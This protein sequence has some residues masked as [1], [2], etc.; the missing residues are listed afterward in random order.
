MGRKAE[1]LSFFDHLD[2]LR[3][4]LIK[5]AA[6]V[7]LF[8]FGAYH[9]KDAILLFFTRTAGELV[10]TAPSDAFAVSIGV[11][12]FVGMLLAMP[13][14]LFQLWQFLSSALKEDERKAIYV[15]GPASLLLFI[16]G[17]LFAYFIVVP[18]SF[19]FLMSFSSDILVPMISVRSYM[20]FV[21]TMVLA[22]GV[23]FEFPLLI[24]FLAKIGVATPAFLSQKRRHAIVLIF[25]VSA[26]I[27]PP[28]IVSLFL[29]AF[30]LMAMYELSILAAR[31]V[32]KENLAYKI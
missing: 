16:V 25:V 13:V 12:F 24:L 23:M 22:F 29:M 8:S 30:P 11:S 19:D 3:Q 21:M 28:D 4:R 5:V 2:E 10:F 15:F 17:A 14:I 26:I 32:N 7:L 1:Q 9:F 20:S 27:T 31:C 18:I 6:S